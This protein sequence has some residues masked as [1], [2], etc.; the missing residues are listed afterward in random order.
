V[1]KTLPNAFFKVQADDGFNVLTTVCGK[2]R[3]MWIRVL[4]GDRV[5]VELDGYDPSR[6][7][8]IFRHRSKRSS[9]A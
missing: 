8:I 9:A 7:R 5:T 3:R 6:G 4:L 2:M 1:Q